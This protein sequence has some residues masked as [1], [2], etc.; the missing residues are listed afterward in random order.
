MCVCVCVTYLG[1]VTVA[2]VGTIYSLLKH[3]M[4]TVFVLN[5]GLRQHLLTAAVDV[6]TSMLITS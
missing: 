5:A 2:W 4:S 6:Q 1:A 3:L